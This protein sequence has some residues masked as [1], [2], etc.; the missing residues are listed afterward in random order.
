MWL[1][2][3]AFCDLIKKW[4]EEVEVEGFASFV[5]ARNLSSLKRS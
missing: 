1:E 4:W 3:M 2:A 5:L